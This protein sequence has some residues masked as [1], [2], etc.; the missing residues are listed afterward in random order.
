MNLSLLMSMEALLPANEATGADTKD[1]DTVRTA[2]K[3]Y[4]EKDGFHGIVDRSKM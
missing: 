4:G 3:K 1:R 2:G